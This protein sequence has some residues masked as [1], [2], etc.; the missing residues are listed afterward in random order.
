MS[1]PRSAI[2]GTGFDDSRPL[3]PLAVGC[4][5]KT[6]RHEVA[7]AK[8]VAAI[9]V[10]PR[11]QTTQFSHLI[12]GVT[13]AAA[14]HPPVPAVP[15]T[16]L[17]YLRRDLPNLWERVVDYAERYPMGDKFKFDVPVSKRCAGRVGL[18]AAD[19]LINAFSWG[20]SP[21]G[22]SY[23]RAI[24]AR[25]W[26]ERA[27]TDTSPTGAQKSRRE[28]LRV[29][30]PPEV[31]TRVVVEMDTRRS[32]GWLDTCVEDDTTSSIIYGGFSWAATSE[33]AVYWLSVVK[34]LDTGTPVPLL[35]GTKA[36]AGVSRLAQLQAALPNHWQ[37]V[38]TYSANTASHGGRG[39]NDEWWSQITT[40]KV[41]ATLD[42][43]LWWDHTP[44][45]YDFWKS[46]Q[47]ELRAKGVCTG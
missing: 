8:V 16:W 7:R 26:D 41:T 34:A 39:R 30:L 3:H 32:P 28:R 31:F 13:I 5:P 38:V 2:L 37:K 27:V 47:E 22:N 4:R 17:D 44:E 10:V 23:W 6:N 36:A 29:A 43:A 40:L 42:A 12:S 45:G 24:R 14:A 25:L 46:V 20:S 19:V 9:R 11:A 18:A 33:G 21:E 15:V 1:F 35:P